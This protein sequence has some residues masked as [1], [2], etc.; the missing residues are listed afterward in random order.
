MT[1]DSRR[2]RKTLPS[3]PWLHYEPNPDRNPETVVVRPKRALPQ[4]VSGLANDSERI[5]GQY[6]PIAPID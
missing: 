1:P 3:Y 4:P 6:T 5:S 2:I